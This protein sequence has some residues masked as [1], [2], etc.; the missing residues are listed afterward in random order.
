MPTNARQFFHTCPSCATLLRPLLG[1]CCVFCSHSDQLCPPKQQGSAFLLTA[2]P[3]AQPAWRQGS[4]PLFE[5]AVFVMH[6]DLG[7]VAGGD[8]P[9]DQTPDRVA[10]T[11]AVNVAGALVVAWVVD[12]QRERTCH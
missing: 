3:L 2:L 5:R 10:S 12:A 1:D 7:E 4:L 6:A 11:P 8:P 9:L